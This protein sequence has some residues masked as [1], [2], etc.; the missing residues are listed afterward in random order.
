MQE[1]QGVH[2]CARA[3][4]PVCR[5]GK[6]S[7]QTHACE[8]TGGSS[9]SRVE[10]VRLVQILAVSSSFSPLS[11]TFNGA[12]SLNDHLEHFSALLLEQ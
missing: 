12:D 3:L 4:E 2:M 7:L 9:C 6:I 10:R 11:A 8:P 5:R 1:S